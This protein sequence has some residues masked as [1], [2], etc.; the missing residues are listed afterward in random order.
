[1]GGFLWAA[2]VTYAGFGLGHL[3]HQMGLEIDQ[4]ILPIIAIIIVISILPPAIHIFK[5]K[6]TRTTFW[7]GTKREVR[8][9]FSK[10]K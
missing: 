10:K 3:F 7:E 8:A 6:K 5:D 4:V 9:I 2:G 1:I